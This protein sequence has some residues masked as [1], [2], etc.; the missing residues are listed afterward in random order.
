MN[1]FF[2][3]FSFSDISS[4]AISGIVVALLISLLTGKS[5]CNAQSILSNQRQTI[6]G[7]SDAFLANVKNS[8]NTE[9]KRTYKILETPVPIVG[10]ISEVD[11]SSDS[12]IK[13]NEED[14]VGI[15]LLSE[16]DM[17]TLNKVAIQ[18]DNGEYNHALLLLEKMSDRVSDQLDE[19]EQFF[20]KEK[21]IY[22]EIKVNFQLGRYEQV[23]ELTRVYFKQYGNGEH[24]F[25]VFYYFSAA[26]SFQE[27]PLEFV[28]LVTED[29]FSY[30]PNREKL[31]LRKLLIKDALNSNQF[32]SALGFIEDS[33]GELIE[34]HEELAEEIIDQIRDVKDINEILERYKSN[35]IKTHLYSK[36][37]QLLIRNN[38][39]QQ[40]Q[41]LY[42]T[43]LENEDIHSKYFNE[44]QVIQSFINVSANTK[45]YKI[46]VIL[47][48]S[49]RYFGRWA[50]EVQDGLELALKTL[51]LNG[52]SFQLVFKDS[53]KDELNP[54][55]SKK[56]LRIQLEE[57]QELI[58]EQMRELVEDEGVIAVLGP[59]AKSTSLTAGEVAEK[60]KIPVISFSK[61]ENIGSHL[62]FLFRFQLNQVQEAK[63]LAN[64][65]MD[66]LQ[67]ERFVIFYNSDKKGFEVMQAF[68]SEVVKK[69]GS[70]V[71]IARIHRKQVD[72]NDSFKSITGGFQKRTEEEE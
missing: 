59:L 5:D 32:L 25:W 60:Y 51:A 12:F 11:I 26:L 23:D 37:I 62:P 50:G 43:L 42:Y 48:F 70:I 64:Y 7:S 55:F 38:N 57:K 16:L 68:G 61:T 69:G 35:R 3:H 33:N 22:L 40:A 10:R 71:G 31:N 53:A 21:K 45:P 52:Q 4:R 54:D 1:K 24:Y 34:G 39:L 14:K 49:H 58:K 67:A 13:T 66:Y 65:A 9:L 47:P 6:D 41:D 18:V 20:L 15:T 28:S 46:G 56:S 2:L 27:K 19:R 63:I 30:L 36:K 72:F 29:F 44:L 8:E 17:A